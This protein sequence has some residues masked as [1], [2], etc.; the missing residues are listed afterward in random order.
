MVLGSLSDTA[1]SS[2]RPPMLAGPIE[3]NLNGLSSPSDD[4]LIIRCGSCV[5]PWGNTVVTSIGTAPVI[6]A[7]RTSLRTVCMGSNLFDGSAIVA[8]P[9]RINVRECPI[10]GTWLST[11]FAVTA[12]G[13]VGDHGTRSNTE[14]RGTEDWKRPEVN[15]T[16]AGRPRD[17]RFERELRSEIQAPHD[18]EV[19][20]FPI[21]TPA[22]KR[23]PLAGVRPACRASSASPRLRV[24]RSA[25]GGGSVEDDRM[26]TWCVRPPM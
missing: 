10:A 16:R 13:G 1:I 26:D 25:S 6:R 20:V 3:R 12:N 17:A 2:M 5:A 11:A 9:T 24:E 23:R 7:T 15:S 21:S 22:R 8:G 18:Q 14:T 19:L 4:W